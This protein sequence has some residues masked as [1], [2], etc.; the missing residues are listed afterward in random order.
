ML[1][2]IAS[3]ACAQTQSAPPAPTP[4]ERN[5]AGPSFAEWLAEFRDEAIA[6]GVSRDVAETHLRNLS[7]NERIY[8]QNDNQPEFARAIWQYL[9]S[10]VSESRLAT[11]RERLAAER[12]RLEAIEAQYGVDSEIIV[13]IW[14]LES[15]YGA[16]M[17]D[18]D[19]IEALATLGWRG[20]RTSYGRS[21]LIGALKII[22]NGY[23][24]RSELRGSWA[25]ALG[26]TQFIPTTYLSYAVDADGD[27]RRDIWS[28]L[29]D[30]FSSTANYLAKSGYQKDAPWGVEVILPAGFDYAA[31]G[32]TVQRPIAEWAGLGLKGARGSLIDEYDLNA[33]PRLL[34][35]AG[36][37]GPAFL[38]FRNFEAILKY[39][40]STAYALAVGYLANGVS[41]RPASPVANWPREDRALTLS[42]RMALQQELARAG[43]DPGPADGV[44]GANT[45]RALRAWQQSR[46]L[47]AD[48]YA[49][50]ATLDALG[51][52]TGV[53]RP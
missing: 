34:L 33:S 5:D 49:S 6:E 4:Q 3:P 8:E 35:P 10:A 15:S 36:A 9:D 18:N 7:V 44:I 20:R 37:N 21:Q 45:Q 42:E 51:A 47:P 24:S 41:G 14:G 29:D 11:G 13:A 19:A 48:G 46:G 43:F 40:R 53:E 27:G 32:P 12:A 17:G 16:I 23:A 38:V 2:L 26:Q 22:Q 52:A 28:N 50:A 30:V 1:A 25:G 31:S 39:N